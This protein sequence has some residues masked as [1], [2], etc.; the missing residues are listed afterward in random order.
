MP[1]SVVRVWCPYCL[2]GPLPTKEGVQLCSKCG[3]W[4]DTRELSGACVESSR[5]VSACGD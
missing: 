1:S 2:K 4:F 5:G 3:A